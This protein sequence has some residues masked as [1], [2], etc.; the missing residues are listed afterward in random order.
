MVVPNAQIEHHTHGTSQI[1]SCDRIGA[2]NQ[3][4]IKAIMLFK[5]KYMA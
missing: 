2:G 1:S 4:A 5:I 3:N